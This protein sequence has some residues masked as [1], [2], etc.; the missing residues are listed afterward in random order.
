MFDNTENYF[1]RNCNQQIWEL[2]FR[3]WGSSVYLPSVK[4]LRKA[5]LNGAEAQ[6]RYELEKGI[7][8]CNRSSLRNKHKLEDILLQFDAMFKSQCQKIYKDTWGVEKGKYQSEEQE[9]N[10][11]IIQNNMNFIMSGYVNLGTIE[12]EIP[13]ASGVIDITRSEDIFTKLLTL[14]TNQI[15]LRYSFYNNEFSNQIGAKLNEFVSSYSELR[16]DFD[17]AL[18]RPIS[19]PQRE[20]TLGTRCILMMT[21]DLLEGLHRIWSCRPL[22]TEEDYSENFYVIHAVS[23]VLDSLFTYSKWSLKRAWFEQ[24]SKSSQSKKN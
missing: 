24:T 8:L 6:Y 16:T 3:E 12:P 4:V 14:K 9:Q 1:Y 11:T 21:F 23:K 5:N 19:F 22:L 13:I 18:M 7:E 20:M 15:L 17:L 2:Y 10:L